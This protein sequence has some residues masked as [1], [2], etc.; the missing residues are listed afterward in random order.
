MT[1]QITRGNIIL[2]LDVF[3]TRSAI[4]RRRFCDQH[5]VHQDPGAVE[6]GGTV[7]IGGILECR[8]RQEIKV[9]VR[10]TCQ[11]V[12][13]LF[14]TRSYRHRGKC[15]FI[16]PKAIVDRAAGRHRP[17]TVARI[18]TVILS[19]IGLPVR[20]VR[21]RSA[22]SPA[23]A[24]IALHRLGP[25]HR[26]AAGLPDPAVLRQEGEEASAMS[27]R[28]SSTTSAGPTVPYCHPPAE[29]VLRPGSRAP[30]P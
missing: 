8:D 25:C 11:R 22:T 7:V 18:D 5:E 26:A 4:D 28:R 17:A 12:G 9:P 10:A 19:L 21:G 30:A 1:P 13:N 20:Q 24:G 23:P 16:T 14:K 27:R 15:R 29:A 3:R 2:D 6:N